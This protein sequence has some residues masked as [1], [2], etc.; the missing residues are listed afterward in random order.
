MRHPL[1]SAAVLLASLMGTA[2]VPPTQ[3]GNSHAIA[4]SATVLSKNT[5][6]FTNRGPTLLPFGSIDPG[7]STAA[8]VTAQTTFRCNGASRNVSYFISSDDGLSP[9]GGQP[10]MRHAL[11]PGQYLPYRLEFP[12]AGS[13]PKNE[14]RTLTVTG[15]IEPADFANAIAGQYS[16]TVILTI[17]P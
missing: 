13:A 9:A 17:E 4:V 2:A 3:A 12:N 10:R 5:C 14:I 8:T 15:R 11:Q 6:H 1:R 16:D 7:A